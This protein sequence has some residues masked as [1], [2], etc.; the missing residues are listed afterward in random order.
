MSVSCAKK[1]AAHEYPHS[2]ILGYDPADTTNLEELYY[3]DKRGNV[4]LM[5][6]SANA[7]SSRAAFNRGIGMPQMNTAKTRSVRNATAPNMQTPNYP[8]MAPRNRYRSSG[9]KAKI[10]NLP[11]RYPPLNNYPY[12]YKTSQ[13]SNYSTSYASY[14]ANDRAPQNSY[15]NN[16]NY[17]NNRSNYQRNFNPQLNDSRSNFPEI[18]AEYNYNNNYGNNY[19]SNYQN[20][21]QSDNQQAHQLDGND[22]RHLGLIDGDYFKKGSRRNLSRND[23]LGYNYKISGYRNNNNAIDNIDNNILDGMIRNDPLTAGFK[24]KSLPS[25]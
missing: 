1:F 9:S 4:S 6:K 12:P 24:L 18:T 13:T 20:N 14:Q 5:P 11:R 8:S 17:Q 10:K 19:N 22:K 3:M 21:D 2:S 7:P 15:Q 23:S 16:R 25:F